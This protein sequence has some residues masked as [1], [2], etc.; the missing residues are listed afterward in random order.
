MDTP[1]SAT[2]RRIL[3]WAA[4]AT[5]ATGI[6]AFLG[7]AR[8]GIPS[9][10]SV[11]AGPASEPDLAE[12]KATTLDPTALPAEGHPVYTPLLNTEFTLE[13]PGET[14]AT[15]RLV[16]V[17]PV[18]TMQTPKGDFTSF[19]LLFE[20]KPGVLSEGGIC[21]VG[22]PELVPME[23]FLSPV[24]RPDGGKVLLEAAFTQRA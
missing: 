15:C 10:P 14:T 3:L 5:S 17:S 12:A 22:H 1:P 23:I 18:R 4:F 13:R 7:R 20:A 6:A 8:L 19:T 2:R 21:R 24:G 11:A 16:E 9:S